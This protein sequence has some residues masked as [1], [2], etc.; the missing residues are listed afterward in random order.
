MPAPIMSRQQLIG[1]LAEVFRQYGYEGATL[2]RMTEKTGLVKA[3]LY[4]YFPAGKHE[5]AEV[6]LESLGEEFFRTVLLPLETKRDPQQLILEMGENLDRFYH[7]GK[8][9]C[10][11]ELFSLGNA[12]PRFAQTL[13]A[14]VERWANILARVLVRSGIDDTIAQQRALD[15]VVRIEGALVVERAV[16]GNGVFAAV[17]ADLP[18]MLLAGAS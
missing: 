14:R 16:G 4:H 3:S 18:D 13:K 11:L 8:A 17:I 15:A 5:M 10:I 1:H 6:V 7:G 12:R 9:S 2:S